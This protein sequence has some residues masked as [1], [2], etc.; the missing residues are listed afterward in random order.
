MSRRIRQ[1]YF[2]NGVEQNV[3]GSRQ[4][5]AYP[6]DEVIG[7]DDGA[8]DYEDNNPYESPNV[9]DL[10]DE[11]LPEEKFL[12]S[13]LNVGDTIELRI[14][15]VQFARLELNGTWH[16]I[17]DFV[18]WRFHI[19]VVK[20]KDE[21]I[22]PPGQTTTPN[23]NI[24]G[25]GSDGILQTGFQD[26]VDAKII[27]GDDKIV[28]NYVTAGNNGIAETTGIDGLWIEKSPPGNILDLTNNGF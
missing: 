27:R 28:G 19:N 26:F 6:T 9:G 24:I 12:Y 15:F 10:T 4:A 5:V 18:P 21:Q 17:S 25:P 23:A 20:V 8:P 3:A 22:V 16:R 7:N 1:R 11:D 13:E 14:Q 2:I